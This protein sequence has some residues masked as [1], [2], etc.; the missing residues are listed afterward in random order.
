[1]EAKVR[2]PQYLHLPY[3]VLFFDLED[4]IILLMSLA[5]AL[6][7]HLGLLLLGS[8]LVFLN[9]KIKTNYPRGFLIHLLYRMGILTFYKY[10]FGFE[11]DF[12]E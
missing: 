10:P 3:Q 12:R 4:L 5:F 2:M 8:F 7:F 6:I 11:K 9:Q 1:M